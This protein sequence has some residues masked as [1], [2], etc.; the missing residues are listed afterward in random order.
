M[1]S[2][3]APGSAEGEEP[4]KKKRKKDRQKEEEGDDVW[5]VR[6]FVPPPHA[7]HVTRRSA[8]APAA[9]PSA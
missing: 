9:P 5:K 4:K 6:P 1:F 3:A 8:F 2:L 7:A